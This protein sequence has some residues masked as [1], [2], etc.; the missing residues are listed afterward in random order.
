VPHSVFSC[1]GLQ[2]VAFK[3]WPLAC[4][5]ARPETVMVLNMIV[6]D[7]FS[8]VGGIWATCKHDL[9]VIWGF[10]W[11]LS[12]KSALF[13]TSSCPCASKSQCEGCS[14]KWGLL[15]EIRSDYIGGWVHA[16]AVRLAGQR[17]NSGYAQSPRFRPSHRDSGVMM[18]HL[19]SWID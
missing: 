10:V 5:C 16:Q 11:P 19:K 2:N 9:V 17:K 6:Y 4:P 7:E 12:V 13:G 1:L 15:S 8:L 18:H 14:C 3:N